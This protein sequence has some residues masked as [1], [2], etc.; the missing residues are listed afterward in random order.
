MRTR[1]VAAG[2]A[3]LS[4]AAAMLASAPGAQAA[5]GDA[6]IFLLPPG[7]SY[8]DAIASLADGNLWITLSGNASFASVSTAGVVTPRPVAGLVPGSS[9]EGIAQDSSGR[10]WFVTRAGNTLASMS[11]TATDLVQTP[12]PVAGSQ[13]TS[14]A[15]TTDGR[16]LVVG[17]ANNTLMWL[18][19]P[20]LPTTY[21]FMAGSGP[22]Y[23]AAAPAGAAMVTLPDSN[24]VAKVLT[25][26]V[27]QR[28]VLPTPG[29]EPWGVTVAGDGTTWFTERAGNRIGRLSPAGALTEFSLPNPNSYPWGIAMAPDGSVWFTEYARS[30]VG[31]ITDTGVVTE[32][33]VPTQ[34]VALT[35]GADG[36]MWVTSRTNQVTRV[37][38]GVVPVSSGAP[39]ISAPAGVAVTTSTALTAANGAWKYQPT[40][41]AYQWQRCSANDAGTCADI[42]GATGSTYT[43]A[44]ADLGGWLRLSV[45]ATNLNGTSAAAMSG[46]LQV[47]AKPTPTPP[48]LPPVPAPVS[49][50]ASVTLVPG[51]TATL[52][53]PTRAARGTAHRYTVTLS[54]PAPKG[55]VRLSLITS[56]GI[57][58]RVL[59]SGTSL[60]TGKKTAY[61]SK[62]SR[63]PRSL[64]KGRYTLRAVYTPP[65]NQAATYPIAT[66]TKAIVVR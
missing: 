65:P 23:A 16:K 32:Y 18:A 37:L 22:R 64:A 15:L 63:L 5:T 12:L 11:A 27:V 50:G 55:T 33:A 17:S 26:Y 59:W 44:D 8:P 43:V 25:N 21:T 47:G 4:L 54:S 35:A 56:T 29:S 34:P 3:L 66:L 14:L 49:G 10:I 31:R 7:S 40:S 45:K 6:T 36:N 41:Y 28:F 51:V 9:P 61:V 30:S 48:P 19:P 13:P 60:T 38:T 52:T 1:L 57:E 46:L 53:A 42:S 20:A 62:S 39:A 58:K 24:T 2:A